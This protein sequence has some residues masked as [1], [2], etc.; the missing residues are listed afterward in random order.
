[1]NVYTDT[2]MF[3]AVVILSP[4]HDCLVRLQLEWLAAR[5]LFANFGSRFDQFHNSG[6]RGILLEIRFLCSVYTFD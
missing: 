3:L 4:M 5:F 6:F 2:A 1:M